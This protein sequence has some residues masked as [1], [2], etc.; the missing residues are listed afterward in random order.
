MTV[1]SYD[2]ARLFLADWRSAQARG[3]LP[4]GGLVRAGM[5]EEMLV[6]QVQ[7]LPPASFD[8]RFLAE[9][10]APG[11]ELFTPAGEAYYS[12]LHRMAVLAAQGADRRNL[13]A[14]LLMASAID[15]AR[16]MAEAAA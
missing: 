11:R 16:A 12:R 14:V 3:E 9:G 5:E 6:V 8:P 13:A 2:P 15:S 1:L 4:M 7:H 10:P